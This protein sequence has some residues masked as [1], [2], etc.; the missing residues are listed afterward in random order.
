M[1]QSHED[2]KLHAVLGT[3]ITGGRKA[4]TRRASRGSDT[5]SRKRETG[6][7][8]RSKHCK[9]QAVRTQGKR[10]AC[11]L[12]RRCALTCP[13]KLV[14]NRRS[15]GSNGMKT[16]TGRMLENMVSVS[17]MRKRCSV[18]F[19]YSGPT[20]ERTTEKAVELES[21]RFVAAP[22]LW[23]SLNADQIPFVSFR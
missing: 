13:K 17:P 3:R 23:P 7:G 12:T 11:K 15:I 1:L 21:A 2:G 9:A 14:F 4:M 20:R 19:S 16:R 6:K 22:R 18:A 5:A 10:R 8:E